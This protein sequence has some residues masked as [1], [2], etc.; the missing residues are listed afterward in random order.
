VPGA[1]GQADVSRARADGSCA[2]SALS[3]CFASLRRLSRVLTRDLPSDSPV[4]RLT[5]P[6]EGS[7]IVRPNP[8][9]GVE[10]PCRGQEAPQCALGASVTPQDRR[11]KTED[12]RQDKE[13]RTWDMGHGHRTWDM[14]HRTRHDTGHGT[15]E[16][17]DGRRDMGH[18]TERRG[19]AKPQVEA[20]RRKSGR[21]RA[22]REAPRRERSEGAGRNVPR[23]WPLTAAGQSRSGELDAQLMTAGRRLRPGRGRGRSR[24]RWC[25]PCGAS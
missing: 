11:Q 13:H 23:C 1:L 12:R 3:Q 10:L 16:T 9:V 21:E 20:G 25:R 5:R 19:S 4:V 15:R 6:E 8:W 2:R 7:W 18:R 17:G 14:G 24:Q 22:R